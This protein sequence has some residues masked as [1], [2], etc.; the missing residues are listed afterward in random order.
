MHPLFCLKGQVAFITG[1]GSEQGIG[2]AAA[3]I[4]AELGA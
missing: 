4:L 2:F 1:A 3:K